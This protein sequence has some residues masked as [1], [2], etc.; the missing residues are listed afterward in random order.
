M[1]TVKV[2]GR[3]SVEVSGGPK[4]EDVKSTNGALHV[5]IAAGTA[6][7]STLGV[8][9]VAPLATPYRVTADGQIISG[10]CI[11][12]GLTCTAGTNP[13]LALYDGTSTGGT[14]V[15]GGA[16]DETIAAIKAFPAAIYCASGLYGDISG[17]GSPGFTVYALA[18]S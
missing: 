9:Q 5:N 1:A 12:Y 18:A 15:Y 16:V 6:V 2:G 4:I 8:H 11:V 7:N 14:P 3:P 10:P 17:T 13:R